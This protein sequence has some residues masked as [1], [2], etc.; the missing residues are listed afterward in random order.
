MQKLLGSDFYNEK[1]F[2][3][4]TEKMLALKKRQ[5]IQIIQELGYTSQCRAN[6]MLVV[7]CAK[8]Y[9]V[10]IIQKLGVK[11]EGI[12]ISEYAIEESKKYTEN[13]K[14]GNICDM[15]QFKDNQFEVVICL[16]TIEHI[17]KPYLDKALDE[18]SRV[19]QRYIVISTPVGYDDDKPDLSTGSDPSL[20][21]VYTPEFWKTEFIK[22]GFVKD[23]EYLSDEQPYF[24]IVRGV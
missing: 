7:G 4:Y 16:S 17:P 20:F 19:A 24:L 14:V 1:Y 5:A 9:L 18:L 21:S 3:D 11:C 23:V 12:D 6:N 15:S 22:R 13:C 10:R 2:S 8:G